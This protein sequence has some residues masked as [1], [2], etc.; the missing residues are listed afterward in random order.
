MSG[1]NDASQR[2]A[3]L[4]DALIQDLLQASDGELIEEVREDGE[5]AQVVSD[6]VA[7]II[8]AAVAKQ[9][10]AAL[11]RARNELQAA[12][13]RKSA[14]GSTGILSLNEKRRIVARFAARDAQL[15]DKLTMAARSG[16]EPTES[17]LDSLLQDLRDLGVIDEE[18]N[19]R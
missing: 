8:T 18:G 1:R 9:G 10:K 15:R 2:L 17:D 12:R 11:A 7:A 4:T 16:Q 3:N 5:D 14:I 13:I 19:E 6:R